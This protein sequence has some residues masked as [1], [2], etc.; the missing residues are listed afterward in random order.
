[1]KTV[2][3]LSV[4]SA[5][6][7]WVLVDGAEPEA[8]TVD[9][10]SFSVS[11]IDDLQSRALAAVRGAQAIASAS[12]HEIESIGVTWGDDVAAHAAQLIATL[13]E[14]GYADVRSV[15]LQ[16]AAA[17]A[18]EDRAAHEAAARAVTLTDADVTA[19]GL[20]V[21]TTVTSTATSTAQ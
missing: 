10:D 15:R 5:G 6:V 16:N 1:M 21:I 11:T 18:A 19:T 13:K 8:L 20:K 14:C 3:G 12:G 2:L 7:G 17:P 9:D 4:T